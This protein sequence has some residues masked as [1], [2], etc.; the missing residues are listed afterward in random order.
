VGAIVPD[1]DGFG[2]PAASDFTVK[3][4]YSNY[5]PV[6]DVVAP[7]D[8]YTTDFGGGFGRIGGTSGATPHVAGVAALVIARAR[9]LR[10]T[11]SA[12]EVV[13]IIRRSA[14]DLVGGP[15]HYRKGWDRFTG[16]GRVDAAA[17][18]DL[19]TADGSKVPPVA[20]IDA[21]EWYRTVRGHVAV[22][23]TISTP[24]C[25]SPGR[26]CGRGSRRPRRWPTWT[27]TAIPTS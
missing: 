4:T 25:R 26:A 21:P 10:L 16:W 9:A 18:V 7:T 13:Q 14:D 15:Y 11:L 24:S 1:T 3:A 17:A 12:Q 20:D 6:I 19:V 5:G 2:L 8:T 22:T 23:G 27:G